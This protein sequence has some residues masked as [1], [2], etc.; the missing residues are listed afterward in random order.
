MF[1]HPTCAVLIPTSQFFPLWLAP[2]PLQSLPVMS[3]ARFLRHSCRQVLFQC[4]IAKE[5][6]P[7]DR[8]ELVSLLRAPPLLQR[9]FQTQSPHRAMLRDVIFSQQPIHWQPSR[10]LARTFQILRP[11]APRTFPHRPCR[12]EHLGSGRIQMHA[13]AHRLRIPFA[14]AVHDQRLVTSAEQVPKQL[15]PPVESRGV[16]TQKPLHPDHQVCLRRFNHR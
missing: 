5:P 8:F 7:P 13:T 2:T 4:L 15:V 11:T 6:S 10:P 3:P 12:G 14:A 9:L 1:P 16:G